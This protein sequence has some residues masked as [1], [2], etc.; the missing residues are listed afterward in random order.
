MLQHTSLQKSTKTQ[1]SCAVAA[2]Q[3]PSNQPS[4]KSVPAS[5]PTNDNSNTISKTWSKGC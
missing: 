5:M 2:M 1:V 4:R 3:N